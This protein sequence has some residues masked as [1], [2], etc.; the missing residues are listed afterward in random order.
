MI[1][2]IAGVLILGA[3]QQPSPLAQTKAGQW[4]LE[5]VPGAKSPVRQCVSEML[6]LARFEH[7]GKNCTSRTISTTVSSIVIEY[8]CGGAGFGRSQLDVLTPRSLRI[9]T[10]GISDSLPF[11]YVLQARRLGDCSTTATS[12]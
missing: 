11:N 10:Q 2:G 8:D 4:E 7:R 6:A 9:S 3:A 1:I 12:H 5:G